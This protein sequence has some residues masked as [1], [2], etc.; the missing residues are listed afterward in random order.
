MLVI[1]HRFG[2]QV[3]DLRVA[4]D[5]GVDLVEADVHLYRRELEIRHEKTLGPHLLWDKGQL[6]RRKGM[7]L[8]DLAAV[9]A[10][11]GEDDAR[12]MLDLKGIRRNLAPQV[13]RLLQALVPGLPVTVCT[14][15]WWMFD[16]FAGDPHVRLVPSAG[17]RAHLTRLRRRLRIVKAVAGRR[18]FA[19]SLRHTI[20]T[21]AVVDE[22]HHTVDRIFVWP[23][24]TRSDL[25]HALSLGADGVISRN[26]E[27]LRELVQARRSAG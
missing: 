17:T 25:E 27:L 3:A 12:L 23:I 24:N 26:I 4:L 15:H 2:N 21:P 5:A 10:E 18:P 7:T 20:L 1:A 14:K 6:V 19:L 9:L 22:L 16:A 13:A 11:L 8:P